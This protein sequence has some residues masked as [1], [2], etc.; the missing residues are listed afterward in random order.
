MI[1][2]PSLSNLVNSYIFL[3]RNFYGVGLSGLVFV[4][5]SYREL[6]MSF[7]RAT[8]QKPQRIIFYRYCNVFMLLL[9]RYFS[10]LSN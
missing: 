3:D 5:F 6:L 7:R 2:P 10:L 9:S 4:A 8:G 1:E